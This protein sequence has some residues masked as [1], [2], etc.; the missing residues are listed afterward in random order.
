VAERLLETLFQKGVLIYNSTAFAGRREFEIGHPELA[1]VS[2]GQNFGSFSEKPH[3]I[4]AIGT[5]PLQ[6]VYTYA[7]VELP[8]EID[9]QPADEET[10]AQIDI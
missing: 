7:Y 4:E 8:Q 10:S 2:K 5:E 9:R 6:S 1:M 3:L